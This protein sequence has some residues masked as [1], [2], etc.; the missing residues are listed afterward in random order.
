MS[1]RELLSFNRI[2]LL[3]LD[4]S[5]LWQG[6]PE[7]L[8]SSGA[9]VSES[10]EFLSSICSATPVGSLLLGVIHLLAGGGLL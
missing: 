6:N 5:L 10:V 8:I 4:F 9:L 3:A 7:L 2:L 1:A